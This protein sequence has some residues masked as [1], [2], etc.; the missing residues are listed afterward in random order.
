MSSRNNSTL[1][2]RDSTNITTFSDDSGNIRPV[3]STTNTT[4]KV[5][6]PF[7]ENFLIF[8]VLSYVFKSLIC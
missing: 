1:K 7:N 3:T 8:F 2:T 5:N 6:K 4:V